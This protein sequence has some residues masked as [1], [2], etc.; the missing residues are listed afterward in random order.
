MVLWCGEYNILIVC[1]VVVSFR[2]FC[3]NEIFDISNVDKFEIRLVFE[4]FD[5]WK[6][7]RFCY[8]DMKV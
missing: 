8:R 1:V 5:I 6:V 7:G 2:I 3:K 4:L